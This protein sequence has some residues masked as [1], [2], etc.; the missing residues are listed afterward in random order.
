LLDGLLKKQNAAADY[1]AHLAAALAG[2]QIGAFKYAAGWLA[3]NKGDA[4]RNDLVI[5][6]TGESRPQAIK[7]AAVRALLPTAD[8]S[9][10]FLVRPTIR[11]FGSPGLLPSVAEAFLEKCDLKPVVPDLV[12]ALQQREPKATPPHMQIF[13]EWIGANAD[14]GDEGAREVLI[15][16]VQARHFTDTAIVA[17]GKTGLDEDGAFLL[18]VM[19]T[20]KARIKRIIAALLEI[21]GEQCATN[22]AAMLLDEKTAADNATAILEGIAKGNHR[23]AAKPSVLEF[24]RD[25]DNEAH[26]AL[27]AGALHGAVGFDDVDT[28]GELGAKCTNPDL[29]ARFDELIAAALGG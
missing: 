9:M 4:Y 8:P 6:V 19:G 26:L 15:A 3:A 21:D 24:A 18:D 22:V 23:A 25:T 13:L 2:D 14:R 16:F 27:V 29:A 20:N 5:A 12:S 17:L 7:D 10:E 11:A 28:L 1:E